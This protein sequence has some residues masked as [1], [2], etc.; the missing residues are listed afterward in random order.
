M[1]LVKKKAQVQG[2]FFFFLKKKKRVPEHFLVTLSNCVV[3][4]MFLFWHPFLGALCTVQYFFSS[5][6]VKHIVYL[7]LSRL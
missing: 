3:C 6:I 7:Y 2:V 5:Y 4:L 1:L